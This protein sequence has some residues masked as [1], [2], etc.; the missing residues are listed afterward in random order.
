M[1]GNIRLYGTTGYVELAAPTTGSNTVLTLPTDSIQPGMMLI[2]NQSFSSAASVSLNNVFTSSYNTYLIITQGT[3]SATTGAGIKFRYRSGGVDNSTASYFWQY[4]QGTGATVSAG[5]VNS[6]TSYEV[7]L[8]AQKD[9]FE[10]MLTNPSEAA[11]KSFKSS[12]TYNTTAGIVSI[13]YAGATSISSAC[14]GFTLYPSSGTISGTV[15]VFAYR[16]T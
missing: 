6:D 2:A 14:D 13:S 4:W 12:S 7:G 8:L 1:P 5:R 9:V 15:R 11:I 16:N 3:H 10:I